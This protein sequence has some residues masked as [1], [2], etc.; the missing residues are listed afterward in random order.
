[1]KKFLYSDD[2]AVERRRHRRYRVRYFLISADPDKPIYG[3][4][5]DISK[6][7]VGFVSSLEPPLSKLN[8]NIKFNIGNYKGTDIH[9]K[10]NMVWR[11]GIVLNNLYRSG[12]E[13]NKIHERFQE[14]FHC[15]IHGLEEGNNA[16][17]S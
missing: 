17:L 13:I 12:L 8:L 2:F 5:I 4:V 9:I 16:E 3:T 11:K 10:G 14:N 7:G 6:S 1:M 15:C